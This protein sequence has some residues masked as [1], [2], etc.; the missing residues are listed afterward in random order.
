MNRW[1]AFLITV[2]YIP[3][4]F[5]VAEVDVFGALFVVGAVDDVFL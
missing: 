3:N 4:D 1:H 5:F 2:T